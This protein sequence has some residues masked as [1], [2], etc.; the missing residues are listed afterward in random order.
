[1][2]DVYTEYALSAAALSETDPAKAVAAVDALFAQNTKSQ[3][4][5]AALPKYVYAI[6]QTN[7]TPAAVALGEKA[8]EA[9]VLNE[10]LLLIMSDYYMNQKKDPDKVIVY[11]SKLADFMST[12][13]KPQGVA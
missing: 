7:N 2:A 8:A 10:D 13:P 6:R 9:G 3:Y 12:R 4:L 1:K 5:E 11:T